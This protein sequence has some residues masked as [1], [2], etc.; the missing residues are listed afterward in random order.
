M[1]A[2]IV[3]SQLWAGC[4]KICAENAK[5]LWRTVGNGKWIVHILSDSD[6]W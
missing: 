1:R 2:R 5:M 6:Y 3:R 4:L